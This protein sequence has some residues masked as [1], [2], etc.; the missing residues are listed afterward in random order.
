M[1]GREREVEGEEKG[2]EG[3]REIRVCVYACIVQSEEE[4]AGEALFS[5][6]LGGSRCC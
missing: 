2:R 5:F 4:T 3:G 1:T 6:L